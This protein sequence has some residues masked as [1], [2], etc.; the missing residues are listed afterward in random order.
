MEQDPLV[1]VVIPCYNGEAYLEEA[2]ESALTQT[3]QLVEIIV[4]DDGSTDSSREIAQKFPYDT[5]AS[6][7]RV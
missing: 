4:V 5:Y 2:I 3:Y 1:S 7:I 6:R